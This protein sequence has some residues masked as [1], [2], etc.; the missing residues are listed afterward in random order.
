MQE[1]A[2]MAVSTLVEVLGEG[3]VK[4]MD[5]FKPYLLM[6]LNMQ[7]HHAPD[8]R[9]VKIFMNH[10]SSLVMWSLFNYTLCSSGISLCI[11]TSNNN[12]FFD[13]VN[14]LYY[15]YYFFSNEEKVLGKF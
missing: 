12:E 6:G 7:S 2:L 9:T 11:S 4:Y 3:F 14:Y 8:V 13:L 5:A 1:D 15:R 10:F